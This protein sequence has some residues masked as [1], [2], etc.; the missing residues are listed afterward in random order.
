MDLSRSIATLTVAG[1]SNEIETSETT[2]N[3]SSLLVTLVTNG[4]T[5]ATAIIDEVTIRE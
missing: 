1:T 5:A 3:N 2:D 4:L